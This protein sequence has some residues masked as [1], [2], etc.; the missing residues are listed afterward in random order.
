MLSIDDTVDFPY[1]ASSFAKPPASVASLFMCV[2][3]L[4]LNSHSLGKAIT[5]DTQVVPL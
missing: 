4:F 5:A 2:C 3:Y 1:F